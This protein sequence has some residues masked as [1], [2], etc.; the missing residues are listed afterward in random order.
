MANRS[1]VVRPG[2]IA[3]S[4][5]MNPSG[6]LETNSRA[7][8]AETSVVEPSGRVNLTAIPRTP[9]APSR[10]FGLPDPLEKR[11][12]AGTVEPSRCGAA[13][14]ITASRV[15]VNVPRYSVPLA[16]SA[17]QPGWAPRS[18]DRLDRL[19]GS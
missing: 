12:S 11:I 17:R 4:R 8:C 6:V 18:P 16:C 13:E 9:G 14:S 7:V 1:G 10:C 15:A 2:R 19:V 5:S 3:L